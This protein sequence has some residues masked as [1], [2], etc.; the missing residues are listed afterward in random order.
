MDRSLED[1]PVTVTMTPFAVGCFCV[2]FVAR[3]DIYIK[4]VKQNNGSV[5]S[6]EQGESELMG[7]PER[8]HRDT[9]E[10]PRDWEHPRVYPKWEPHP[11]GFKVLNRGRPPTQVPTPTARRDTSP[12]CVRIE[13]ATPKRNTVNCSFCGGAGHTYA[14]CIVL[15]QM[16]QE[17]AEQL[18]QWHTKEYREA[19]SRSVSQAIIEE[20]REDEAMPDR[21][22]V[23][24]GSV[25]PSSR[26]ER[27]ALPSG[28]LETQGQL[29]YNTTPV[30]T[31]QTHGWEGEMPQDG[32]RVVGLGHSEARGAG[33]GGVYFP[34]YQ[35]PTSIS[36]PHEPYGGGYI[37]GG[38][39]P[40]RGHL[41]VGGDHPGV[42]Q[43]EGA[44]VMTPTM[45]GMMKRKTTSQLRLLATG[46]RG[47][48]ARD[49][50][51][52]SA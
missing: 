20:Y 10:A 2:L 48:D 35:R 29:P 43:E 21:G 41:E 5:L 28:H 31:R 49:Y 51:I 16:V 46:E 30:I 19:Q 26:M 22:N 38:M 11:D 44:V 17:Q 7:G 45:A 27:G 8:N 9:A 47:R 14:T 37:G 23:Y 4:T 36:I 6:R 39:A 42:N 52:E 24:T 15:K 25:L 50:P 34:R 18:Q 1:I 40:F 33:T 3:Q 13:E 32:T 12:K